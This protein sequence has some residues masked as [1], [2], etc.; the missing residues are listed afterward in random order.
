MLDEHTPDRRTAKRFPISL[1]VRYQPIGTNRPH[2]RGGR[3]FTVN[4][5]SSGVLFTSYSTLPVKQRLEL[6][7]SWPVLLEGRLPLKLVV[8]GRVV[9]SEPGRV[10][11]R[12]ECYEFHTRQAG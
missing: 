1:E 3:G 11:I 5:S 4:I 7:I 10:A 12:I 8:R 9:R 2:K 6:S